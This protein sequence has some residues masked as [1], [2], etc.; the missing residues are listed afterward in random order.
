MQEEELREV[1]AEEEEESTLQYDFLLT[2]MG[3]R[4]ALLDHPEEKWSSDGNSVIV[5]FVS[6][7]G[8]KTMSVLRREGG[9]KF[10]ADTLSTDVREDGLL[11]FFIR[12]SSVRLSKENVNK[13][14]QFGSIGGRGLSLVAFE[15]LMKGL[16]EKQ[17]GLM[18]SMGLMGLMGLIDDFH[19]DGLGYIL[20]YYTTIC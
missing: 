15:R 6:G 11:A 1:E 13:E 5:E 18:G 9:V 7:L 17:V 16:V 4:L 8:P 3:Q 20:Y 10:S 12:N 2:W 14:I 19:I